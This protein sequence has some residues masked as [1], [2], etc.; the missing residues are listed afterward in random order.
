MKAVILF[1][2]LLISTS[3]AYAQLRCEDAMKPTVTVEE[4]ETLT[5]KPVRDLINQAL[6]DLQPEVLAGKKTPTWSNFNS[7]KE[8]IVQLKQ[9]KQELRDKPETAH[10]LESMAAELKTILADHWAIQEMNAARNSMDRNQTTYAPTERELKVAYQHLLL[11]LNRVLPRELRLPVT[12]FKQ[13]ERLETLKSEAVDYMKKFEKFYTT[14]IKQSDYKSYKQFE[15]ELRE[16]TDPNVQKAIQLIDNN[17]LQ[18]VMRR[19]VSGRFWVP[20]VGFQNQ[21]VTSSSKGLLSPR[22]R[23]RAERNL[24][25]QED[26]ETYSAHDPEF[27]PKYGTLSVTPESGVIPD[28]S[29]STQYGPDI[30]GFKTKN[31]QDRL[32]AFTTDSLSPGWAANGTFSRGWD[33]ALIPWKRRLLLVPFMVEGLR[34]NEFRTGTPVDMKNVQPAGFRY[35]FE[36]QILGPVRLEDVATFTFTEHG[37]MPKGQFLRDLIKHHI[38][39]FD[40]TAGLGP[41]QLKKWTPTPED[42]AAP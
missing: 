7:L 13:D 24:Y 4:F 21:F 20:K 3:A 42:L 2:S 6:Y 36:T 16:S 37:S 35:Y 39:I 32:S 29:R 22:D 30:Y 18:V 1:S 12:R 41:K 17:Q 28:L 34:S 11:E 19:P 15:K 5:G 8:V 23:N 10:M 14:L 26:L 38:E 31:I 40:G 25:N 33:S 27:K 9:L